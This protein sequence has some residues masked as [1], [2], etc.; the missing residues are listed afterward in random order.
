MVQNDFN[1]M[2]MFYRGYG[3]CHLVNFYEKKTDEVT[4]FTDIF[5]PAKS[6]VVCITV[7]VL[8]CIFLEEMFR[9]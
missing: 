1:G 4:V 7:N 6:Y 8:V 3:T 2:F 5:N 9:F